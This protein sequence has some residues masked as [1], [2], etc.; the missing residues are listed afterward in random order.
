MVA[1]ENEKEGGEEMKRIALL[2]LVLFMFG[3]ASITTGPQNKYIYPDA[4]A[5]PSP[6]YMAPIQAES[7]DICINPADQGEILKHEVDWQVVYEKM[8]AII[9]S[10]NGDL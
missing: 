7:R 4:P 2:I 5:Y 8:K 1:E 9:D 6:L 3:C 10:V